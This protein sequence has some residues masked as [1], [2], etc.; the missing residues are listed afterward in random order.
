KVISDLIPCGDDLWCVPVPED[1]DNDGIYDIEDNCPYTPNPSQED[2]DEDGIGD[3]CDTQDS[4]AVEIDIKPCS[5]PNSI[6]LK[7]KGLVPVAVLTNDNFDAM[8]VDPITVKFADAG[9]INW[10][11][12]DVG[13]DCGED[14]GDVDLLLFYKTQELILNPDSTE[15]DLFGY[16]IGGVA[17]EGVDMVKIVH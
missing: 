1:L 17:I 12:E 5:D 6:N 13:Y 10:T 4:I 7:A 8:D 11:V 15:A 9:P 3:A 14:D 2:S 16:T